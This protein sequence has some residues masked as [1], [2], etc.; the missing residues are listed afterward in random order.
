ME[1][2]HSKKL[3]Y[4]K[5]ISTALGGA[6]HAK[7]WKLIEEEYYKNPKMCANGCG[8]AI[9]FLG[10]IIQKYCSHSCAAH[11][12]GL[13]EIRSNEVKKKISDSLKKG[14][15]SGAILGRHGKKFTPEQKAQHSE[16]MKKTIKERRVRRIK[17]L[18]FESLSKKERRSII[19]GEQSGL[20]ALCGI[21]SEWNNQPLTLQIDHIDG[22]N[23][24][25]KRSNLR[26]LCPNC[27]SQQPTW[28]S[29]NW[30]NL[31]SSTTGS[32]AAS[33]AVSCGGSNPS[34]S[35]N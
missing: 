9:P 25:D 30:K 21:P 20:C 22:N 29:K 19:I 8:R 31:R 5:K 28:G 1:S 32:A 13:G 11:I 33:E 24:C 2:Q 27:H 18:P 6:A 17:E 10:R 15:A 4:D 23:S 7:K 34:S 14:Y 35:A 12:N 3:P 26:A 16:R